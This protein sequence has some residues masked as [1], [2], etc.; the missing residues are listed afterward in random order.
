MKH[1]GEDRSIGWCQGKLEAS[2][3]SRDPP[4]HLIAL[5]LAGLSYPMPPFGAS[6]RDM[7]FRGRRR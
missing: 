4:V 6:K 7:V 5:V 1:V 3:G 2:E